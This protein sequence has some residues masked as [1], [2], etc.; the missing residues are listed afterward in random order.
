M[1][2]SH[3][4]HTRNSMLANPLQAVGI[5]FMMI[6]VIIMLNQLSVW[7]APMLFVLSVG[8]MVAVAISRVRAERKREEGEGFRDSHI[9]H[10]RWI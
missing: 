5:I 4:D 7:F 3:P 10:R 1:S 2:T 6:M 9:W 8:G